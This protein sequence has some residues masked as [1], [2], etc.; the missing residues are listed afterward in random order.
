MS[1]QPRPLPSDTTPTACDSLYANVLGIVTAA[2]V[3]DTRS[4]P[5]WPES[6]ARSLLP[7]PPH[8]LLQRDFSDTWHMKPP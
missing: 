1:L 8:S 4:G 2:Q 7:M 3:A 5:Y 6:A